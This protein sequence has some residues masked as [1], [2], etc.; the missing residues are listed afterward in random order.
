MP[1]QPLLAGLDVG[2]TSVKALLVTV[3]G[4]EVAV[5]RAPTVWTRTQQGTEADPWH[6][7]AAAKH[8]LADA[9]SRAPDVTVSSVGVASLAESG[10]L[11][12]TGDRPLAPVIAWHDDRD[13][14]QLDALVRDIGGRRF[15]ETTGLPLRTQWSLTKHRW[16]RDHRPDIARAVRRYN[17]AEWVV[18]NL[19]GE[20]ASEL[21]LASRTGWLR[22]HDGQPW[23]ETLEWSGA[24]GGVLGT[25]I[26]AGTPLGRVTAADVPPGV[27]GATLTVAGHDHQAAV[28]GLGAFRDGD[29][30]DSCGTAEA[31]VRTVPPDLSPT[32]VLELTE[33]G[34]T[35][36]RHA[37]RDRLCLLGATQ[38][39]LVLQNVLA[40]LGVD[41]DG[42][43]ELDAA[44]AG[45]DPG[46]ATVVVGSDAHDLSFEG[47]ASP[48]D[49]WA[50]ATLLVTR[51]ARRISNAL[52]AAAGPRGDLIVTGGWSNSAALMRAK[53]SLLG[54]L[55]RVQV[56]EAGCRGGALLGGLAAGVYTDYR[57]FPVPARAAFDVPD[58]A[59]REP[60]TP[61]SV[62][63]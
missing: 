15:S 34:V 6:F 23:A 51:D 49:V 24:P 4:A 37:V 9:M 12:D 7:V 42:V 28:I 29:E 62:H 22:L 44:A 48:G 13:A 17:I 41:R 58:V 5:G 14:D 21:S 54:S 33:H 31:I 46:A 43:T 45:A 47:S 57:D 63:S 40:H 30:V 55:S 38:G 35:V 20:S 61:S 16:L 50:A 3:D 53:A 19:G 11:V 52:T 25:L 1:V 2:T 39:G 32:A 56:Q 10:V 8:A 59:V 26:P 27:R 36:G 60:E 18:R